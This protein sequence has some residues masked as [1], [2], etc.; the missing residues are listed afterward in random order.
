MSF[1]LFNN[2]TLVLTS[3]FLSTSI[4]TVL[5]CGSNRIN[6]K[7]RKDIL[8]RQSIFMIFIIAIELL[9]SIQ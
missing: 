4:Y 1:D 2:A 6:N 8:K 3:I 5:I 9:A 7:L